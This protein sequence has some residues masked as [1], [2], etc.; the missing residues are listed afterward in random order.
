MQIKYK[1]ILTMIVMAGISAVSFSAKAATTYTAGD[2]ILGFRASGGTGSTT[3]L[4]VNIGSSIGI[5]DQNTTSMP[6]IDIGSA[7][8]SAYG[9]GWDT[10]SDLF[11]GVVGTRTNQI[12]DGDP[13]ATGD[14]AQT[15]YVSRANTGTIGTKTSSN[16]NTASSGVQQSAANNIA[17]LQSTFQN[18]TGTTTNSNLA[19][20]LDTTVNTTNNWSTATALSTDFQIGSDIEGV[21]GTS[22]VLDLYRI[23]Q[24]ATGANPTGTARTGQWQG[25]VSISSAGAVNFDPV[26]AAVPEPSR[27]MLLAGGFGSL[28]LRRR[29]AVR[30]A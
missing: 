4:L 19:A 9:A 14:P 5:R 29:R 21:L 25:T 12:T 1:H 20:V 11:W 26:V 2:L 10:R 23:L 27:V 17:G 8:T 15:L 18:F 22:K 3:N 24:T 13:L 16:L 30:V 28:L 7:L 6:L